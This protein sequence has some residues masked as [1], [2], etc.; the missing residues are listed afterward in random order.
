VVAD[1]T[2]QQT[3]PNVVLT[4]VSPG[5]IDLSQEHPW[6]TFAVG[7]NVSYDGQILLA[8]TYYTGSCDQLFR[9]GF[10]VNYLI[11]KTVL[12]TCVVF[13]LMFWKVFHP[14]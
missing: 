4:Q 11:Y 2:L 8:S 1:N 10:I 9:Y 5:S 12:R 7:R 14:P 3:A 13:D 6:A